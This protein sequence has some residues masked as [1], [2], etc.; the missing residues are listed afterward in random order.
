[1]AENND[2]FSEARYDSLTKEMKNKA[3]PLLMLIVAKIN[4]IIKSR[5]VANGIIQKIFKSKEGYS[6]PAPDFCGLKCVCA[7]ISRERRDV[8][9]VYLPGFFNTMRQMTKMRLFS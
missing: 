6:S 5:G 2:C 4:G 7:V 3:F 9:T 1:M 8:D